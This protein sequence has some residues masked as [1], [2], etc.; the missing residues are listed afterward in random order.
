M[1]HRSTRVIV[2]VLVL[3]ASG[4]LAACSEDSS[5]GTTD[6]QVATTTATSEA[7]TAGQK[8]ATTQKEAAETPPEGCEKPA[9]LVVNAIEEGLT[10]NGGGNLGAAYAVRSDDFDN[11]WMVAGEIKG[12]GLD[13]VI[14]VWAT[15]DIRGYGGLVFA[16]DGIAREFSDWGSGQTS[17]ADD[18]IDEAKECLE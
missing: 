9:R 13:K 10:V 2:P 5:E 18:G 15:N 4:L 12:P 16:A 1:S 3:L 6:D 11:V 17:P 7:T 14:G 8:D